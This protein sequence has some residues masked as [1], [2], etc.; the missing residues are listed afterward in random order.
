MNSAAQY[1]A[2]FLRAIEFILPHEND[3]AR[4]HWGD[5]AF[6]ITEHV[7][8]DNGGATKYGIDAA[9][10][11]GVNI[12]ALTRPAAIAIYHTEWLSHN[13]DALPAKLAICCEDV[14]VN[15]GH[16]WFWLQ[17]ALNANRPSSSTPRLD[18]DGAL[19]PATIA[20]ANACDQSPVVTA[21]LQERDQRFDQL[22][23]ANG[24][25]RAFLDGWL[26]RDKDLRVF[27][28]S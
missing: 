18:V 6:V 22:A 4:G 11:P 25:D 15:G 1:S 21:F 2:A 19:G 7:P 24:H 3:Y 28:T 13:L 12:D 23:A 26:Q 5:P 16:A 10:H 17:T 27:L 8:G 9:S 14:W 20:A